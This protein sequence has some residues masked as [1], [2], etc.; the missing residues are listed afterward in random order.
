VGF[1]PLNGAV[2]ITTVT[3]GTLTMSG[4]G[5]NQSVTLSAGGSWNKNDLAPGTYTLTMR[6]LDG[7]SESKTVSITS[8]QV[9]VADFSYTSPPP[10]RNVRA[11]TP[12]TDH[13]TLHWDSAEAGVSYQVHYGMQDNPSA[14]RALGNA[15]AGLS[16]DVTSLARGKYYYFWVSTI[17]DDQESVKSPAVTVFIPVPPRVSPPRNVR[18]GTPGTDRVTLMW[19]SAGA[20]VSYQIYYSTQNNLSDAMTLGNATTGLSM[21]VTSL[22]SGRKY[23][24]WVSTIKDGQESVKSLE[25]T[26][27]TVSDESPTWS[28]GASLG[29][30]FSAPAFT[31]TPY[32]RFAPVSVFFLE[33]GCDFGFGLGAS[34]SE[35]SSVADINYYSFYPYL[36][37][38]LAT[39]END[40]QLQI[41]TGLGGGAMLATYKANGYTV[42]RNV[43]A[44]DF[45]VGLMVRNFDFNV[46]LRTTFE[47]VSFRLATGLHF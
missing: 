37:L 6:Y 46:V 35:Y 2:T 28:F 43:P 25:V 44:M 17:K 14:A 33:L 31:I 4:T 5:V 30:T 32:G 12:G 41:Y 13:V 21:D 45:T 42:Q 11:G 36:H 39:R 34:T 47:F 23:Y 10:P 24:F 38:N 40:A 27:Q 8:G 7:K 19:D 20:G 26:V 9:M 15:T 22:T 1:A 18:A 3:G 16:M 29:T